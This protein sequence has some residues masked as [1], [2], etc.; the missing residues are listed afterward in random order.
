MAGVDEYWQRCRLL[1]PGLGP[2]ARY[3][4]RRMGNTPELCDRLLGM[5]ERGEKTGLFSRPAELEAVG[6]MPVVGDHVVFVDFAG[7]PRCLARMEECRRMRFGD[8][9]PGETACES[10]AA[11]DLAT[12]RRIH[13]GYWERV[14]AAEGGRFTDDLELLFQRFRVLHFGPA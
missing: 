8:V 6:V 11:R 5:V 2:E 7:E 12:W 10:P 3:A 13:G 1:V 4:V 9:G 14:L